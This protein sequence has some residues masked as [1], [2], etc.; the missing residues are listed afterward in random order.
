MLFL[1]LFFIYFNIALLLVSFSGCDFIYRLLQKEGAEEKELLGELNPVAPSETV[2][3][4]QKILRLYGYHPG[5]ADGKMGPN[6]RSAIAQ[7]QQDNN[8]MVNKFLDKE[9]WARLN[10]L[11]QY[12]LVIDGEVNIFMVQRALK[13]AGFNPGKI[14]GKMGPRTLRTLKK[15]QEAS[16]LKVDGKIGAKTLNKLTEHLE[17]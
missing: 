12:Q 5:G 14:D 11:E 9:T 16:G 15:F 8:L 1:R 13:E 3:E 6:T 10:V 7:F 2:R 4:V 17:L